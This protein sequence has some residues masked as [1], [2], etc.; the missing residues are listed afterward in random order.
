MAIVTGIYVCHVRRIKYIQIVFTDIGRV[1]KV[2]SS[3]YWRMIVEYGD[4][5]Q[6]GEYR[7]SKLCGLLEGEFLLG[8][9]EEFGAQDAR[10]F[11]RRLYCLKS[12]A[13]GRIRDIP[14]IYQN[15]KNYIQCHYRP[16]R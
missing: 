9:Y 13:A 11:T 5:T 4:Y 8:S 12:V 10:S 15:E 16:P 14:G 6:V 2:L 3:S 7:S 1:P